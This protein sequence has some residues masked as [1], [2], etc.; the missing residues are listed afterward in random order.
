MDI[1]R[2]G[3]DLAD[4]ITWSSDSSQIAFSTDDEVR[5]FSLDTRTER[6]IARGAN[7]SWSPDGKRIAFL[8]PDT[9][10]VIYE[11]SSGS[12]KSVPQRYKSISTTLWAPNSRWFAIAEAHEYKLPNQNCYSNSELAV[13]R[14][15][16]LARTAVLNLCGL[17]P[18]LFGWISHWREWG[19]ADPSR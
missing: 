8:T 19:V 10:L 15:E 5:V 2:A 12:T 6:A 11:V 9:R 13:Y 1:E 7:P 3:K 4:Q 18:E 17:K 16:D 14:L